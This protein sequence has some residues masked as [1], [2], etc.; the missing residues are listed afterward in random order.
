MFSCLHALIYLFAIML[1][2]V[3]RYVQES[4]ARCAFRCR[5]SNASHPSWQE[6]SAIG[7][8]RILRQGSGAW[9]TASLS[10]EVSYQA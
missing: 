8:L 6:I 2:S 4:F 10:H 9:R 3:E 1:N 5:V 7:C